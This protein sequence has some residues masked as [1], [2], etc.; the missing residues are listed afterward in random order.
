MQ[1]DAILSEVF[2]Q[3]LL[4]DLVYLVFFLR[5][6]RAQ[7]YREN[8]VKELLKTEVLYAKRI[9]ALINVY[10]RPLKKAAQD[11]NPIISTDDIRSIFSD[12][13]IILSYSLQLQA[14]RIFF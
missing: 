11:G 3:F 14:V 8:V 12:I 7:A 9:A 10:V 13:E 6:V 4:H 1:G 2:F 5:L